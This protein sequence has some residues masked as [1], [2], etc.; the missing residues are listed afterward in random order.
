MMNR[1]GF[2]SVQFERTVRR[3][4]W[5][6]ITGVV[7]RATITERQTKNPPEPRPPADWC[8]PDL[9]WPLGLHRSLDG[10]RRD[11]QRA[12]ASAT[13]IEDRVADRGRD[14]R[15]GRLTD[16]SGFFAIGNDAD[17][18]FRHLTHPERRVA[19]E[20]G[21]LDAA[22]LQRR[23]LIHRERKPPQRRALDLGTDVV[24]MHLGADVGGH[25]Q[26]LD[27]NLAAR[28]HCDM[29]NASGPACARPFL[30]RNAGHAHAL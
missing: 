13:G 22:V 28:R 27:L 14:H 19:V 11:W 30:R 4:G 3:C 15:N 6:L 20:V 24:G 18:D 1:W 8:Y 21:L 2:W 12:H 29:R 9:R 7:G 25:G 17:G 26:L 16:A 10:L 5:R 23:L